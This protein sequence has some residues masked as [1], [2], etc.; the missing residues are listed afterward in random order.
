[1]KKVLA[2][3]TKPTLFVVGLGA[4]L[5]SG[6]SFAASKAE[7]FASPDKAVD[8]FI[9]ASRNNDS[10][11]LLK[12]FGPAAK[13]LIS[14]GDP[15]ADK[16]TRARF[17]TRYGES[18]K[19]LYDGASRATLV[20]GSD[21]WPFPMPLVK[22]A[23]AW[24]FDT[25][26][27]AEEV[28]NRRIGRNELG[29]MEV[30]RKY[31]MAQREYAADLQSKKM[32]V[33]YAQ[34]IFS[35]P[36]SHDGLYWPVQQ[37]EAESPLGPQMAH[38]R[39]EGYDAADQPAEQREPYHGY[40]YKILTRQG[41]AASG[42]ARDD[43]VGGHLTG[44]FALIAF[45]AKYG[46]SGVMSFIVNEAGIVFEKDLGPNTATIAPAIAEYNPDMTWKTR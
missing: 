45:P 34:K 24:H 1:M 13:D 9:A 5:W 25:A 21:T 40:F 8:A 22:Q 20:I 28:L 15:V 33:E 37:G 35:A 14:S 10:T 44:G 11:A 23:G 29:A 43:I 38:A 17:V 18:E 41:A 16:D 12:I 4:M 46:N 3:T 32:P 39:A 36:G 26:A 2:A 31:V 6:A 7:T 27:G 30:C 42:G 19:I